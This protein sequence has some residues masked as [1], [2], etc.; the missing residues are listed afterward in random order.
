MSMPLATTPA[1]PAMKPLPLDLLPLAQGLGVF[2]LPDGTAVGR[3]LR[4][5]L[6]SVFQPL[7]ESGSG[8]CAGY[9]AFVRAHGGG[10]R[11]IA[12]WNL[13]A[14]VANDEALVALD[15][16]C[17]I[18]HVLN[19]LRVPDAPG[20]L[21]LNVQGR[22]LAAVREDHGHTFRRALDRLEFDPARIVIETPE[23]ANL[24]R[25]LL[26]LV[27]SSYRLNGFRVAANTLGLADLE[28][29][30]RVVRSD[31]VKID[32]RQVRAPEA[33]QR[34]V[35]IAGDSG[36]RPVFTRIESAEQLNFLRT[37]PDV[38]LQGRAIAPPSASPDSQR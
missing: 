8:V 31:F 22:L 27:L 9:E 25:K 26:A 32:A 36:T 11:D 21:F 12:P 23:A 5:D 35:S 16:L 38:L 10:E 19:F 34:V 13:F 29:L 4:T 28:S 2:T 15:R 3:F 6:S 1:I 7:I 24:D 14:L 18:V 33:M 30:L 37:L 17:R 20:K